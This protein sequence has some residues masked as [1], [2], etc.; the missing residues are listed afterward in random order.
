MAAPAPV[1][2]HSTASHSQ[3]DRRSYLAAA[4]LKANPAQSAEA[5]GPLRSNGTVSARN[6]KSRIR[7]RCRAMT[8]QQRFDSRHRQHDVCRR[9]SS[10]VASASRYASRSSR[11][12]GCVMAAVVALRR[13][14]RPIKYHHQCERAEGP[15]AAADATRRRGCR[16][17]GVTAPRGMIPSDLG[18]DAVA[19][20]GSEAAPQIRR[21]RGAGEVSAARIA[22]AS[23]ANEARQTPLRLRKSGVS[24]RR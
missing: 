21:N 2:S 19:I 13:H 22:F 6:A 18:P 24:G 7:R 11:I 15:Q 23:S 10:R 3:S 17:I 16:L 5:A 1:S 20:S 8:E 12:R 4:R 9:L 14:R